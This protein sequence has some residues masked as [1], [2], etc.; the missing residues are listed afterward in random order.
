MDCPFHMGRDLF[1]PQE[2]A[3]VRHRPTQWTCGFC[4]KSFYEE[5]FLDLHFDNRHRGRVN[6]VS[7]LNITEFKCPN[8]VWSNRQRIPFASQLI[9]IF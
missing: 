3:K 1:S 4:G 8:F 6:Q 9:V 5:K 2:E 7:F